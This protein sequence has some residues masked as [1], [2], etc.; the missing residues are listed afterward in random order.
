MSAPAFVRDVHRAYCAALGKDRTSFE[1]C[2][3]E[4]LRMSGVYWGVMAMEILDAGAEMGKDEI[5]D[6][7]LSCQNSDGGFG[8]TNGHDSHMLYTLSAVQ[9]LAL[10]GALGRL[11]KD[12]VVGYVAGLQDR[13]T[14]AFKGDKWGEIDTRFSYCALNCLAVL[15]RLDAAD[16]GKAAE[17][18]LSCM[19]FDGGFGC[20]PGAESHAGQIFTC[21]GTLSIAGTWRS[22]VPRPFSGPIPFEFRDCCSHVGFS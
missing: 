13:A 2:V 20:V 16:V 5:C 6:W 18:V 1:Y 8:G 3:T 9:L 11:D 22:P 7:V 19:N 21:V 15:G 14:G 10:N 4:H 17:F 12:S